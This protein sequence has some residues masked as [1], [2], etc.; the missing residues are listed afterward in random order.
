MTVRFHPA[1]REDIR[2]ARDW[3]EE[4]SPLAA[5]GFAQD[6]DRAIQQIA[7]APA[8]HPRA[9]HGTR[10]VLLSRFPFTLFYRAGELEVTV[11]AVAHQ[12]RRPGY[13]AGR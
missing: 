3:Y 7:E 1:A 11:I 10:R 8:R 4:R 9:E 5:L 6:V 2:T 12:K 13:W